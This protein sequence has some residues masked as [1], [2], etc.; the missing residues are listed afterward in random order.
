M[1]AAG[2]FSDRIASMLPY[3]VPKISFYKGEYFKTGK[4]KGLKR[5]IYAVPPEDGL[6]LG[7]HTRNYLDGQI[8]FGPNVY[9]VDD[10]DYSIDTGN[11]K[12]FAEAINKYFHVFLKETDLTPDYAGIRPKI[13]EG[14]T[15][16]DFYIRDDGEESPFVNLI[17][18]ESPGLT[19][20]IEIANR[21]LNMIRDHL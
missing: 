19:C 1:N 4:I 12:D 10:V 5:L 13:G 9:P 2:L 3:K 7:I 18:I 6:S 14:K 11:A 20:S 15:S 8:S 17:G 16:T 21:V